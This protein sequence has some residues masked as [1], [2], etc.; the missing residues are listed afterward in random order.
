M[1]APGLC[2]HARAW[3]CHMVVLRVGAEHTTRLGPEPGFAE[4][5]QRAVKEIANLVTCGTSEFE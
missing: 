5:A 2:C 4:D 1:G 3:D